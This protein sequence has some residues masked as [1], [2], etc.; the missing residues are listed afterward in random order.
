MSGEMKR[1]VINIKDWKI[2]EGA[3]FKLLHLN[4]I[5]MTEEINSAKLMCQPIFEQAA[6]GM[7]LRCLFSPHQVLLILKPKFLP[8]CAECLLVLT[9]KCRM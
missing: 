7:Y 4:S 2:L 1:F 3:H 9:E 6:R 5:G 8:D